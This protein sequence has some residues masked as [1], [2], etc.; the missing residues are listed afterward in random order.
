MA[1]TR[2]P[3]TRVGYDQLRTELDRLR[4]EERVKIAQEIER[5]RSYGDLNENA[6]YQYAKDKQGLIEAKIRDLEDKL[7]RAEVIDIFKL[8]GDKVVFGASVELEDIETKERICYQI[9]GALEADPEQGRISYQS[10]LARCLI[11]KELG[12]DVAL[13]TPKGKKTYEIVKV[14][15][16]E[17]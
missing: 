11:G 17:N 16:G 2:E 8:N 5:A 12:D 7:A 9:V 1:I 13:S 14:S 4:S 3:M 10:P 6:E 15:F